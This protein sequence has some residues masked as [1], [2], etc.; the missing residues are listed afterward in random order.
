MLNLA[1]PAAADEVGPPN[2]WDQKQRIVK[3]PLPE[4][5]RIRF[6]TSVDYPPFNFLDPRGRLDGFNVDLARAICGELSILDRC[7]IEARPFAELVPALK[8]GEADA[9]IAGVAM[10]PSSR[11]DLAFTEPYFRYPARFVTRKGGAIEEPLA[12][13]L[14][15]KTVGLVE[16][17]AHAAMFASFFPKMKSVTFK[18]RELALDALRQGTVDAVFSDGVGLSFWLSS[19]AAGNCCAFSGGPYLSDRFLGEGLAIAVAEKDAPLA[20]NFDYAIGQLVAKH[21]FS[22]IMLRYFPVS[23]F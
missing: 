15:G 17:S 4:R 22:D 14:S 7:Q 5:E 11:A 8:N 1:Q 12:K 18:T 9:I 20:K 10:T 21:R 3:P 23:P 2:F 19:D 16:D 13:N 6:L